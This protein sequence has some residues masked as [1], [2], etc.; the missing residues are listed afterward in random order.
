[1]K[2]TL[3]NKKGEAKTKEISERKILAGVIIAI[4]IVMTRLVP[5]ALALAVTAFLSFKFIAAFRASNE[6]PID[7]AES[8]IKPVE[9]RER[10]VTE[11]TVIDDAFRL[12]QKRI[13]ELLHMDYPAAIWQWEQAAE[14]RR[15]LRGGG[16]IP[17]IYISNAG[18]FK[19][20]NVLLRGICVETLIY[21]NMPEVKK[22]QE[23]KP[24][25]DDDPQSD[26]LGGV[27]TADS[28][29]GVRAEPTEAELELEA[30]EWADDNF[31]KLNDRLNQAVG[32][33]ADGLTVTEDDL[34]EEKKTWS[35]ICTYL[36]SDR[37]GLSAELLPDEQGI[38]IVIPMEDQGE[39]V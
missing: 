27:E 37:Y 24:T 16:N 33:G 9:A 28:D 19:A 30:V 20:A 14:M 7:V 3:N 22:E 1:M 17:R 8:E 38:R 6:E 39:D 13:T 21:G 26:D 32:E 15:A 5:L 36:N 18:G 12:A 31:K 2:I 25:E 29:E 35:Y 34:P 11:D 23:F 10:K 4:L